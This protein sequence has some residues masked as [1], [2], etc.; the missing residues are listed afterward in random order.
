M[1][2]WVESLIN[3]FELYLKVLPLM[4]IILAFI[5]FA[6]K[7][8]IRP[9]YFIGTQCLILYLICLVEVVLFPL[10][11]ADKIA[12]MNSYEGQFIPFNFVLDI[13]RDKSLGSV[14][15]VMMNIL[16]TVPFGFFF[17]FFLNIKRRNIILL[18]FLLSLSIE[19]AQ[20]TGLFFTYPGSYR[21][22]DVDDLIM[23]TLG[24]F[25]GTVLANNV[26]ELVPD[27]YK[28]RSIRI[29]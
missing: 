13:A 27:F 23:N 4:I 14:L 15:Q 5:I 26:N 11:T 22:F 8:S 17:K 28:N 20:L 6:K 1:N 18:T 25:L 2:I 12:S 7:N 3:G 19:L 9:L 29:G 24:G 21:L 16:M 10:P